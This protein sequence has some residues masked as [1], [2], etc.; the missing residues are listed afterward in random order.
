MADVLNNV[1]GVRRQ[2]Y[3]E[4]KNTGSDTS[5]NVFSNFSV[6]WQSRTRRSVEHCTPHADGKGVASTFEVVRPGSRSGLLWVCQ[7][8]GVVSFCCRL[9]VLYYF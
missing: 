9:H 7:E 1:N 2:N 6:Q 5:I 3:G 8:V 4:L